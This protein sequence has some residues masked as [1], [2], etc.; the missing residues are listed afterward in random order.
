MKKQN[1]SRKREAILKT[2]CNTDTH[3]TAEWICQSLKS[4]FP[5]LSLGTV[6]RNLAQLKM[7]GAIQSI[8]VIEGQ[9]RFDGNILLHMH[10]VCNHCGHIYDLPE[11]EEDGMREKI[12]QQYGFSVKFEQRIFYG[13]CK[14]CI[15]KV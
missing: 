3:P 14:N 8:G 15:V 12:E 1:F 5:D 9:E 10:F 2:V 11:I 7:K 4:D 13:T 6:Y